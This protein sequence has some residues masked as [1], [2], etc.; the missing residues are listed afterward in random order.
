[1][2]RYS[3][4]L[5]NEDD[6]SDDD[7]LD[8]QEEVDY[9]DDFGDESTAA[10][11]VDDADSDDDLL[12]PIED[13][14]YSWLDPSDHL[15][16]WMQAKEGDADARQALIDHHAPY[17]TAYGD[18]LTVE[19]YVDL[20]P[21]AGQRAFLLWAFPPHATWTGGDREWMAWQ[22]IVAARALGD[23]APDHVKTAAK[24]AREWMFDT[25]YPRS[26]RY[27]A[28]SLGF[29]NSTDS[30]QDDEQ[31]AAIT[32]LTLID[33]FHHDKAQAFGPY[34]YA[35]GKKRA[36]D[37]SRKKDPVRREARDSKKRYDAAAEI[38]REKYGEGGFTDLD[39]IRYA[40]DPANYPGQRVVSEK[41]L[42]EHLKVYRSG[43]NIASLNRIMDEIPNGESHISTSL[44]SGAT[45]NFV[46]ALVDEDESETVRERV[47]AGVLEG[48]GPFNAEVMSSYA[49]GG[50][51]AVVDSLKEI[52]D[53]D[54][55]A[56]AVNLRVARRA[57]S[58]AQTV[59]TNAL[60]AMRDEITATYEDG[61]DGGLRIAVSAID[62][63][64]SMVEE[65]AATL[66]DL[67]VEEPDDMDALF[68][69]ERVAPGA[70]SD[71]VDYVRCLF[72]GGDRKVSRVVEV[73]K[74]LSPTASGEPLSVTVNGE[75]FV[76]ER[77]SHAKAWASAILASECDEESLAAVSYVVA[78]LAEK[79]G[80]DPVRIVSALEKRAANKASESDFG[81]DLFSEMEDLFNETE[82]S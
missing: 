5:D 59:T 73:H 57:V 18:D 22:H 60:F 8:D 36:V 7:L 69:V 78:H 68:D 6:F 55:H 25:Y 44:T 32:I 48:I 80:K 2:G 77:E 53:G 21:M 23:D 3:F 29:G 63:M 82:A 34:V 13:Y 10:P 74:N 75:V 24:K 79:S 11:V 64:L 31:S 14:G 26:K 4:D 76:F 56:K 62:G 16:L 54:A 50:L 27:I 35:M 12:D 30:R 45:P 46:D 9:L 71:L 40:S 42:R 66:N 51:D 43:D 39:V 20:F 81:P 1:M 33:Q 61:I 67:S 65:G 17:I 41:T 15:T 19:E 28:K 38:L 49:E 58:F 47:L 52:L 72:G 37:E 70:S